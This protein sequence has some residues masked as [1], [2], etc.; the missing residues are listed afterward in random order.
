MS[1][2]YIQ[3]GWSD[4]PHISEEQRETF[5]ANTAPHQRDARS[6][7]IPSM[8]EGLIY[9]IHEDDCTVDNS[10]RIQPWWRRC[11]A[12]DPGYNN[13]AVVWIA[14]DP[15]SDIVYVYDCFKKHKI[16][17]DEASVYIKHRDV[18]VKWPG[19]IDP[20]S[21]G[22]S[23]A[24]GQADQLL[25]MYNRN[26][27]RLRIAENF[28]EPGIQEVWGRFNS[29]RLKIIRNGNTEALLSEMRK[30]RRDDKGRIVKE[31]DHLMDAL[32]Y[33]IVSGLKFAK[34]VPKAPAATS[35]GARNYGL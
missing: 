12:I 22:G 1:K 10:V 27:L 6:K 9:P 2:W 13:T 23:Q 20:A 15:D 7:G 5:L 33:A 30:Y 14:H 31:N 18:P 16:E 4:V 26:G 34:P 17:P 8:G 25:R 3:A 11:Y 24:K 19:V 32:R 29:G 35:G 28:V 21:L